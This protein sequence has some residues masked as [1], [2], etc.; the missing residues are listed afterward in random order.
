MPIA[1]VGFSA[2]I[3]TLSPVNTISGIVNCHKRVTL[4]TACLQGRKEKHEVII[5]DELVYWKSKLKENPFFAKKV[6]MF[7]IYII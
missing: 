2:P 4:T 1:Y 7:T 5:V 3:L 6:N